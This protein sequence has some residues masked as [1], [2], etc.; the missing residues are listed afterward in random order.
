MPRTIIGYKLRKTKNNLKLLEGGEQIFIC[1]CGKNF[2]VSVG[3]FH[4]S[5]EVI[6][7]HDERL[8][9]CKGRFEGNLDTF[10]IY[11]SLNEKGE[12]PMCPKKT[13]R[14]RRRRRRRKNNKS[15]VEQLTVEQKMQMSLDDIIEHNKKFEN[16]NFE[17]TT[18]LVQPEPIRVVK[19]IDN[20]DCNGELSWVKNPIFGVPPKKLYSEDSSYIPSEDSLE[21]E[22][23]GYE[24]DIKNYCREN[25]IDVLEYFSEDSN[26]EESDFERAS[27]LS[28]QEKLN[29][30][31]EDI[32]DYNRRNGYILMEDTEDD[33]LVVDDKGKEEESLDDESLDESLEEDPVKDEELREM[34]IEMKE[35]VHD[36]KSN[37]D[38]EKVIEFD[39]TSNLYSNILTSRL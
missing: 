38:A 24:D 23:Y 8:R 19:V 27:P 31:L 17:I 15:T 36:W 32:I 22:Y 10:K 1:P 4:E 39:I 25:D 18:S 11:S 7:M 16:V 29:M 34:W 26:D 21:E 30:S 13:K 20:Y 6:K 28:T 3:R 37:Y 5:T 9:N 35:L 2:Y 33:E 14:R 12:C